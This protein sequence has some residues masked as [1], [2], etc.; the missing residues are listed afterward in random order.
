MD[1]LRTTKSVCP[2]C[3]KS[4]PATL[5]RDAAGCVYLCKTCAAHGSFRTVVWR[6]LADYD[7]WLSGAIPLGAE[8][9]ADCPGSC[10]HCSVHPQGTC[11]ALVEVTRRC[12]LNCRYC[13]AQNGG[14]DIPMDELTE[15]VDIILRSGHPL[16]QL[17]GGEPTLRDDL[18]ELIRYI[19]AH[20]GRYVQINTNGIRLA[21]DEAYVA[22]LADAGLNIAFLQFDG[23]ED[24]IYVKLR[25]RPLLD[26]KNRA[27]ELCGRY[28][29]GV[30]LVPTVVR[31][32]NDHQIGE[33]VQYGAFLSPVVRGIHFQPVSY[34]GKYPSVPGN[35]DRYTLDELIRALS[36]QAGL[37]ASCF[38]PS[39]CDHPACGLHGSFVSDEFG[40]LT[41]L[42][43]SVRSASP[44]RVTAAENRT[45]IGEHWSAPKHAENGDAA[46]GSLD[47]FLYRA[48]RYGFTITSM[49]FQDAMNLDVERLRSCSLHV[50]EKGRLI[51]FCAKYLTRIE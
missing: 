14:G 10:G 3:L 31:G 25:G 47:E 51:P 41:P 18:P 23:T 33:I 2:R 42:T 26:I 34:F 44:R 28:G 27:I 12:N 9:G 40:E 39:H 19:H 24:E 49:A 38:S 13:F 29:I 45:Y 5:E 4:V 50:Y 8:E 1:S 16:I 35:D 48:G 32:V 17:S 7:R 43:P 20:G 36:D 37:D 11:C 30:T 6:G 22:A 21:G 46:S 15:A